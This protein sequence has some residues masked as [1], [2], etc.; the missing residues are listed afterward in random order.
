M[1]VLELLLLPL[2]L[3]FIVM[4]VILRRMLGLPVS[5]PKF[6]AVSALVGVPD[7]LADLFPHLHAQIE[8]LGFQGPHWVEMDDPGALTHEV[9]FAAYFHPELRTELVLGPPLN[10]AQPHQPVVWFGSTGANGVSRCSAWHDRQATIPQTRGYRVR[11]GAEQD[12]G[13]AVMAH[14]AWARAQ[15]PLATLP[16][17]LTQ[18]LAQGER[19]CARLQADLL[20]EG[21][22]V[23][24]RKGQAVPSW[25]TALRML[26]RAF[27]GAGP[28][29]APRPLPVA[30]LLLLAR[31]MRRCDLLAPDRTRQW[32]LFLASVGLFLLL[33]A[34][35]WNFT[36]ALLLLLVIGI[37][38]LGH[39]LA[40]RAMGYRN[41]QMLALP[42]VGGVAMGQ[43][44]H[45]R[46]ADRAWMSLAGPLPGILI[47]WLLLAILLWAPTGLLPPPGVPLLALAAVLF[48]FVNYLNLLPIPPLDG[49]HV[50]QSLLPRRALQTQAWFVIL[51]ASAGIALALSMGWLL[52]GM[53]FALQ[54]LSVPALFAQSRL[55]A[56]CQRPGVVDLHA[57][58]LERLRQVLAACE[59]VQG[60]ALH[61]LHR[62]RAAESVLR[63]LELEPMPARQRWLIG[64]LILCAV[65]LPAL[66]LKPYWG[67]TWRE[68]RGQLIEVGAGQRTSDDLLGP[69]GLACVDPSTPLLRVPVNPA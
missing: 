15:G 64:G 28:R 66:W 27:A 56:F 39:F 38:E 48:L 13:S 7:A 18:W 10:P 46:A 62:I 53:L 60:P 37:H 33:G 49:G 54:L 52:L 67:L 43:E 35:F 5:Q 51:A 47:G 16:D 29:A 14:C 65:G 34:V 31:I 44:E 8:A 26:A 21:T 20:A 1:N 22:F 63:A 4:I 57:E 9:R 19:V 69:A 2:T 30:R 23:R 59:H 42:L 50:V 58:P 68:L 36:V 32:T 55:L 24:D 6:R 17:T 25:S 40:M 61:A 3:L 41:T 45:P 12:L 11:T